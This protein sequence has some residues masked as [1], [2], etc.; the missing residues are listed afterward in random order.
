MM[1][2]YLI[3]GPSWALINE[4]V[5]KITKDE[6]NISY[7]NYIDDEL[8]TI[9][10]DAAHLSLFDDKKIIIVKNANVFGSD[11]SKEDELEKLE[12]YLENPNPNSIIIFCLTE[13]ADERRK[14]TKII[15]DKYTY[16]N[17]RP[18]TA[19]ELTNKIAR[20]FK[21]HNLS[22]D[23]RTAE[24]IAASCLN[25]YDLIWKEIEKI[26]TFYGK[27]KTAI[28]YDDVVGLIPRTIEENIF[29]F[30]D[31]VI[32]KEDKKMFELF[33]DL[34]RINEEPVVLLNNLAREFRLMYKCYILN[35][36]GLRLKDIASELKLQDWQAEK[37]LKNSYNYRSDDI[38]DKIVQLSDL[39][40][41]IKSG[42]I[43]KYLGIEMFLLEI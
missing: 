40:I 21:E 18:M 12:K 22:V 1:P 9:L 25:N 10:E 31:A 11:K 39:D 17:L 41:A 32:K 15:K 5:N 42:K 19:N 33:K 20:E 8:D 13:K 26:A 37:A 14:V 23:F 38:L 3:C 34:K 4:E 28:E 6:I 35:K 2:I 36:D 27:E 24:Y 7:F 43:D 16:I 29:R 30:S